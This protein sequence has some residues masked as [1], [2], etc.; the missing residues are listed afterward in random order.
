MYRAF[1]EGITTSQN[2]I[3]NF[4]NQWQSPEIQSVYE[5]A[6]GSLNAN[7]DLSASAQVQRYGWIEKEAK[8]K[9]AAT[10]RKDGAQKSEKKQEALTQEDISRI[11][12][13]FRKTYPKIPLIAKNENRDL[14]VRIPFL[15]T[16]MVY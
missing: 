6:R 7:S 8:G 16:Y 4:R 9:R 15:P 13:D 2:E 11:V 14:T 5:H 12:E 3:K 1:K 10:R